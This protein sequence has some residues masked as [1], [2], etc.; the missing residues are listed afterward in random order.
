VPCTGGAVCIHCHPHAGSRHAWTIH[1]LV[2]PPRADHPVRHA[3][4]DQY[5]SQLAPHARQ[6]HDTAIYFLRWVVDDFGRL[7]NGRVAGVDARATASGEMAS[8]ELAMAGSRI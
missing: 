5:G 3:V 1:S 4:G 7:C 8:P 2:L 6:R